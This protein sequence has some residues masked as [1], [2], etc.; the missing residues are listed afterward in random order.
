MAGSNIETR[1]SE[2]NV[3]TGQSAGQPAAS[4]EESRELA[5]MAS[6]AVSLV[7]SGSISKQQQ[8]EDTDADFDYALSLERQLVGVG[9]E[10][11]AV[12]RLT[13]STY[14]TQTSRINIY[15]ESSG[16]PAPSLSSSFSSM[17]TLVLS[18][19]PIEPASMS[20]DVA[21]VVAYAVKESR[22]PEL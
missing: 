8:E 3:Y 12:G 22:E 21:Y 16:Q 2:I 10:E 13:D 15:T 14:E 17:P 19:D 6:D 20:S 9:E 4:L 18:E 5:S 11:E 7:E 1:T